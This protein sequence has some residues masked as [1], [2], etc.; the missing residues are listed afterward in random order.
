MLSEE[1]RR[2]RAGTLPGLIWEGSPLKLGCERGLLDG[3]SVKPFVMDVFDGDSLVVL[4]LISRSFA[5][6]SG[7]F[8]LEN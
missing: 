5:V 6:A 7:T 2:T 8:V 3:E 4:D 1:K